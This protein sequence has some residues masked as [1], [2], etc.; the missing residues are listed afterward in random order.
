MLRT[1]V[2]ES[3]DGVNHGAAGAEERDKVS[4]AA[5]L[6]CMLEHTDLY[7]DSWLLDRPFCREPEL[8]FLNRAT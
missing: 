8:L 1:D 2:G 5:V 4:F 7:R 3:D 6:Y